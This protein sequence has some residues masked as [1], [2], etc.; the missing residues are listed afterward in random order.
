MRSSNRNTSSVIFLN[1]SGFGAFSSQISCLN[2]LTFLPFL[3]APECFPKGPEP[4]RLRFCDSDIGHKLRR[5]LERMFLIGTGRKSL[6]KLL[7]HLC[8]EES[9]PKV[10]VESLVLRGTANLAVAHFPKISRFFLTLC[11]PEQEPPLG[12]PSE[13]NQD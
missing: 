1:R 11:I 13:K 9:V 12:T 7:I 4:F 8:H 5:S 6:S 2:I 3:L 10:G